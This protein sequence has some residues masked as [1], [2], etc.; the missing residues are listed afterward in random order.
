MPSTSRTWQ[1]SALGL[2]L[3]VVGYATVI[4]G[5]TLL[6]VLLAAVVYLLAWV[7]DRASPGTPLG[8]MTHAR[9]LATG[10][11]VLLVLAYSVV[12]AA[13]FLLGVLVSMVV[14][15]VAWLTSPLGPVARWLDTR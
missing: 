6:G 2:A 13:S 8:D 7:I 3:L 10:A 9:R 4:A 15:A 12:I 14:V 5:N 11:V 1:V